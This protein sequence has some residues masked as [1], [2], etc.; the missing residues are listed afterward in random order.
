MNYPTTEQFSLLE[1]GSF[2]M[3]LEIFVISLL[4]VVGVCGNA[5]VFIAVWKEKSLRTTPNAFVVNLAVTD[6][7]F[8]TTVL[9]V[10]TATFIRGE[11]ILSMSVCKLQAF[12]LAA[13]LNATLVTMTA[14]SINRFIT[15]KPTVKY[16]A[17]YTKKN[18]CV[19]LAVIWCY[20]ILIA[21]R[22]LYGLGAYY[23]NQHN[24]FCS[25]DNKRESAS[26]ISR[27]VASLSLYSNIII[28]LGCYYGVYRTVIK[29]RRQIKSS[30]DNSCNHIRANNSSSPRGED[31]HI[32]KTL[33]IVICLFALCWFPTAIAGIMNS[34]GVSIPGMVQEFLGFT[35]CL[36]SVLNPIVYAIRNRRFRKTFKRIIDAHFSTRNQVDKVS[37]RVEKLPKTL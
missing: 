29:H 21:S 13:V 31:V 35:V 20:S 6:F 25:I 16:K 14:I 36:S 8:S 18:V 26:R 19:I 37:L 28:I 17:A 22:P 5:L 1:R 12:L 2:R 15:I 33:F 24:G 3:A 34:S 27:L 9:P 11:W 32:A 30:Q 23:F 10:T 4:M 7:L